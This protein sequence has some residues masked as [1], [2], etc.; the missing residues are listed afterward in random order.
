[1]KRRNFF[2]AIAGLFVAPSIVEAKPEADET[3]P[4]DPEGEAGITAWSPEENIREIM[5]ETAPWDPEGD[6]GITGK[7]LR[8]MAQSVLDY[9]N[10]K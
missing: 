1:M 5:P 6:A 4:W 10:S 8:E 7:E 3:A 2:A 9:L